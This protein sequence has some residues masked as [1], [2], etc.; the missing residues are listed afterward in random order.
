LRW[1]G[2]RDLGQSFQKTETR[3]TL[4]IQTL[5]ACEI[6]K[7]HKKKLFFFRHDL[8]SNKNE[9]LMSENI[10]DLKIIQLE[11][12]IVELEKWQREKQQ[13]IHSL[14]SAA[15]KLLQDVKTSVKG[16]RGFPIVRVNSED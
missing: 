6:Q 1:R 8:S 3:T 14:R 9:P 10:N 13:E 11:K 4:I 12:D 5:A 15:A 2:K 7:K 16:L